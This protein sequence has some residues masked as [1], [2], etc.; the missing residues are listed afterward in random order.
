M[1]LFEEG[2]PFYKGNLHCHTTLSDGVRTPQEVVTTYREL[3]YDF[4]AITDHR[5]V[6]APQ[7]YM[8]GDMLVLPGVELDYT[9]ASEVV[10]IVGFGMDQSFSADLEY[11]LG[12]N[13]GISAIN[14]SGGRA[15]V[16][17]PYWSLN[18]MATLQALRGA[19]AAEVFNTMSYLRQD[20][21]N[22]LD[23]TAAR[24]TMYPFVASDDSHAYAGEQGCGFTM[25]Q[26]DALTGEAIIAAMDK[27]LFYAS[28]GPRIQ[29]LEL[30]DDRFTVRC[31]P[32]S[33]VYF[34]SN[35]V[36]AP[37]YI[38]AGEGLTQASYH[39]NR[40]MG[41]RFVRCRVID[42]QGKSA[43]SSPVAL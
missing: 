16:A 7:S 12:P 27:G 25:V 9:L 39:L 20:S 4:L 3:G 22:I 19:A 43:W 30:T 5:T 6:A 15:I 33:R 2:K 35:L 41:E 34:Y 13:H 28:Q 26:A 14:R 29:Q 23:L 31:S 40:D 8:T 24:G 1:L 32:A 11:G 18:T 36:W 37:D 42:A 10:H 38:A 21:S 17:H